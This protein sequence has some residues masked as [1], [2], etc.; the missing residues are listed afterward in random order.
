MNFRFRN[1]FLAGLVTLVPLVLTGYVV[2]LIVHRLGGGLGRLI[3]RLPYVN[4]IPRPA[5]SIVAIVIVALVIYLV[6]LLT[7]SLIGARI[8][9]A[10]TRILTKLPFIKGV[11][12]GSR[13][14][15][16]TI[17]GERAA[18]RR[19][20]MTEFPHKGSYALGFL[21]S[22][23]KWNVNGKEFVNVFIPTT[24]NPTSGWYL[25]VPEDE[26]QY[27]NI[28]PEEGIKLIVSGG[29]LFT[30]EGGTRISHAIESKIEEAL[31]S[32]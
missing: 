28:T 21:T 8:I 24:P 14:L 5:L 7:K 23:H 10:G 22:P 20:V 1:N 18:F 13:Q 15:A 11:Y 6:G 29:I 12:V 26:I 16:E 32:D 2:Y 4:M 19:V 25:I 30:K 9:A 3:A 31:E 17:L 27:L